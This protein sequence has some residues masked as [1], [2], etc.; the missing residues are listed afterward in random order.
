MRTI[1]ASKF[2][3]RCLALLDRVYETGEPLLITRRG[4]VIAQLFPP[5]VRKRSGKWLGFGVGSGRILGDIVGPAADPGEWNAEAG[6][7]DNAP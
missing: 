4:R 3:A 7:G 5:T 6:P 2:H 1:S